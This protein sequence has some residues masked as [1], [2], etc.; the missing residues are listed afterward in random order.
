MDSD[1]APQITRSAV[2][3]GAAAALAACTLGDKRE[4]VP[5][6]T[7]A[8]GPTQSGGVSGSPQPSGDPA[9]VAPVTNALALELRLIADYDE[10]IRRA[11][12]LRPTLSAFR[13][14]HSA[15][16]QRLG[17]LIPGETSFIV[18]ETLDATDERRIVRALIAA[19]ERA[20]RAGIAAAGAA[21]T[22]ELA[23]LLAEIAG[24]EAQ[25]GAL[26]RTVRTKKAKKK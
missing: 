11:P 25:H 19:E 4:P 16:A 12:R 21:P 20:G 9:L 2:L 3:V 14:H 13:A 5:T 23:V 18:P 26:L 1:G 10:A 24:S 15:H 17:A 7:A 22:G 6:G 8:P